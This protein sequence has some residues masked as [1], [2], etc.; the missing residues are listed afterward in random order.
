MMLNAVP[1]PQPKQKKPHKQ[2]QS[3]SRLKTNS[4][5]K[6]K[7]K[8]P[9]PAKTIKEVFERDNFQCQVCGSIYG[10]SPHHIIKKSQSSKEWKHDSRNLIT[11]CLVCHNRT[12]ESRDFFIQVQELAKDKLGWF[13]GA[14][15]S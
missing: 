5:L 15:I 9:L 14:F 1:K 6:P 4:Q 12:E 2:L 10:L 8:N 11:L 3:K 7:N 13:A